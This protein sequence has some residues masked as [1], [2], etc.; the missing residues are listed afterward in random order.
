MPQAR[1]S[2]D[3]ASG[4]RTWTIPTLNAAMIS[5]SRVIAKGR[6]IRDVE[7]LVASYGWKRLSVGEEKQPPFGG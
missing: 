4:R 7:R 2:L 1:G 5:Q 3:E 6:R